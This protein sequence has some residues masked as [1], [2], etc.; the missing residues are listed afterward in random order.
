M[1]QAT[2]GA[3]LAGKGVAT[4]V[5]AG[6]T[7]SPPIVSLCLRA[8]WTLGGVKD[9]YLFRKNAGDQ[10]VGRCASC[11]DQNTTEFAVSPPYFDYSRFDGDREE[12]IK[13]MQKVKEF[14]E[15]RLGFA[16]KMKE[17]AWTVIEK[18]FASICFHYK[19]LMQEYL[20]NNFTLCCSSLFCDI[21]DE[22]ADLSIVHHP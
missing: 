19:K 14:I 21:P 2:S 15:S 4:M 12:K 6:C 17:S 10:Y 11:L 13:K 8:G 7:V 1:P 5:A 18:Y 22:I 20:L 3:T 16:D 9:K